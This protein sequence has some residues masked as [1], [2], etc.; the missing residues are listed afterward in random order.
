[1][2]NK[3]MP[4]LGKKDFQNWILGLLMTELDVEFTDI[5]KIAKLQKCSQEIIRFSEQYHLLSDNIR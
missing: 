3:S 2:E 4:I 5:K 1:M